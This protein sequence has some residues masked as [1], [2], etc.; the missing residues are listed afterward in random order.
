VYGYPPST[1]DVIA[2]QQN[3]AKLA[4]LD[5]YSDVLLVDFD[6]QPAAA[7]AFEE[8]LVVGGLAFMEF[9]SG[10]R[11]VHFHVPI[12]PMT[13]PA[14]AHSQKEWIAKNAP[15]ADD[16]IYKPSGLFRL[17]GTW[18]EK[19]P[20]H[21]K[22]L[23]KTSTGRR[24]NIPQA[25]KVIEHNPMTSPSSL[26]L[27]RAMNSR[28][29]QGNRRVHAWYIAMLA[30][31]LG[32]KEGETYDMVSRWNNRFAEPKLVEDVICQKVSEAYRQ[33]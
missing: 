10:N 1:A 4:G 32:F 18:H 33:G 23:T 15:L 24:L 5:L 11:S 22:L 12:V 21:S 7:A 26:K 16:T 17:P 9:E 27:E 31:N 25:D 14:T 19:N 2:K 28:R 6:D 3:T 8:L 13:G 20:G 29:H 30:Y